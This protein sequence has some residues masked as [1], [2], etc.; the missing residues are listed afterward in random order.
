MASLIGNQNIAFF[1]FDDGMGH[2]LEGANDNSAGALRFT[3]GT[4]SFCSYSQPTQLPLD[5]LR[6]PGGGGQYGH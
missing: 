4:D 2:R 6:T 3:G 5:R 1:E